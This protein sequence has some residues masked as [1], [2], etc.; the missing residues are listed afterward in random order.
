MRIVVV[1]DVM[2]DVDLSGEATRL[3]P[4]APVPVVDVSGVKRRAGG[5]GLVAR[6]LA[7]DGWPVTL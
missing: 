4:D 3:S 6:M 1:G 7:G 2:L 5:A